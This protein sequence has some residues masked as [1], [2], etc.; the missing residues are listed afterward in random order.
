MIYNGKFKVTSPFGWR[1]LNG[2]RDN[3]KGID[4]V[5]ITDKHIC[6]VVSG[7]VGQSTMLDPNR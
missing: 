7:T 5:G 3:H 1:M 4:V 2:V 6:A